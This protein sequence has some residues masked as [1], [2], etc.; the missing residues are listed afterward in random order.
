[1]NQTGKK[2]HIGPRPG[3]KSIDVRLDRVTTI[4]KPD[5]SQITVAFSRRNRK[6]VMRVLTPAV[7]VAHV[8]SEREY[9]HNLG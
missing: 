1:M 5:G 7:G 6:L 2:P 9:L 8:D 4:T 3:E